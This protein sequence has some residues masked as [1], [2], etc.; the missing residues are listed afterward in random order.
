MDFDRQYQATQNVFGLQAEK[1][2][3]DYWSK[4]DIKKPVPL[5]RTNSGTGGCF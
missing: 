2:L 4:I 1:T 5:L 3:Q